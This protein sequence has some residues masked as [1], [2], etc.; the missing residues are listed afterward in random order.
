MSE[1]S[2][3]EWVER[4]FRAPDETDYHDDMRAAIARGYER[5][6]AECADLAEQVQRHSRARQ[7]AE[8]Q[9]AAIAEVDRA[10]AAL[11]PDDDGRSLGARVEELVSCYENSQ[12]RA[13]ELSAEVG[14]K[15][16]AVEAIRRRCDDL[17]ADRDRLAK[18]CEEMEAT[19]LALSAA[20][21][22][23]QKRISELSKWC[24]DL[25]SRL[26]V[27]NKA[28]VHARA[29]VD[30]YH[31][32]GATHRLAA[33]EQRVGAL[34]E[35][36]WE[37]QTPR[38]LRARLAALRSPGEG[39]TDE[40]PMS[41]AQVGLAQSIHD[42]LA[43]A[44][45]TEVPLLPRALPSY[46]ERALATARRERDEAVS[47]VR[48][49]AVG[50][51]DPCKRDCSHDACWVIS[52]ARALVA[53]QGVGHDC[54]DG[55]EPGCDKTWRERLEWMTANRDGFHEAR[56]RAE[57]D[58]AARDAEIAVARARVAELEA[59]D[60]EARGLLKPGPVNVAE[61]GPRRDAYLS[62]TVPPDPARGLIERCLDA[63]D[64]SAMALRAD[65]RAYLAGGE[66]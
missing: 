11:G 64:G 62:G 7:N 21:A 14:G 25:E 35:A 18:R 63:L 4:R 57:S 40:P 45:C 34:V 42:A 46:I 37:W 19:T 24:A 56:D 27:A 55:V 66:T 31:E 36:L 2:D 58:L 28:E 29:Q 47:V 1:M 54:G 17:I 13:A 32:I 26:G 6:K 59:R 38:E 20:R 52:E 61:W 3:A 33:L 39:A 60:R 44:G 65:L 10:A 8:A 12:R 43:R 41:L 9:A 23:D 51:G 15:E 5:G 50:L 30:A 49:C 48:R 22:P 53:G 16:R